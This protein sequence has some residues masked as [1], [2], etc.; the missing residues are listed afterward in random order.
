[1]ELKKFL[2]TSLRAMTLVSLWV[3]FAEIHAASIEQTI[4][5]IEQLDRTQRQTRVEE[6]AKKQGRIRWASST[7]VANVDAVL[8][9]FRKKYPPIALEYNRLSGRVLADRITREYQVGKHEVDVLGPSAVSFA[10]LKDAGIVTAYASP[11]TAAMRPGTQDPKGFWASPSSNVVCIVCNKNKVKTMPTD[12]K[13]FVDP[14]WKGDFSIDSERY[15]WYY[16]LTKLYGVDGTKN[17]IEAYVRNGVLVYRSTP[18][19]IQLVAAGEFSCALGVF[20]NDVALMIKG[21]A[22]L[23][24]SIPQPIFLNPTIIMMPKFPP[25]PYGAVLLYDYLLSAEGLSAM[26]SHAPHMPS[27]DDVA[28]TEHILEIR[29]KRVYFTEVEEQSRNFNSISE[30]YNALLKKK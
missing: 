14:R 30:S 4:K 6:N 16:A 18:L 21:G 2:W 29:S 26:T 8:Q 17:L 25:N 11:E 28:V 12:W 3:P 9:S 20:L 24:Y 23:A 15:N 10:S 19:Q 27:R 7:P 13:D 5:E 1:M 22:P